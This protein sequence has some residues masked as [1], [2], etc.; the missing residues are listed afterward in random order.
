MKKWRFPAWLLA[1]ALA[2]GG[3]GSLNDMGPPGGILDDGP[4]SAPQRSAS[5]PAAR[6]SRSAGES[7]AAPSVRSVAPPAAPS[8][9]SAAASSQAPSSSEP[10]SI[11]LWELVDAEQVVPETYKAGDDKDSR[12]YTFEYTEGKITCTLERLVYVAAGKPYE[13]EEIV[14]SG[15]W[16][17]P[18]EEAYLP[19]EAVKITLSAAV[20][21]FKRQNPVES[22]RNGT[23]QAGVTVWAYIDAADAPFGD[24][25]GNILTSADGR[26]DCRATINSGK[27][28]VASATL[29]VRSKF[30]PGKPGERKAVIG[31]AYNQGRVGGIKYIFQIP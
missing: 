5:V 28:D 11:G 10:Q 2:L 24:A 9:Q 26:S 3:C 19:E 13:E 21:N 1:A 8:S 17:M 7:S 15:G 20:V 31:A 25:R 22:G 27:I 18:P 16:T 29:G 6:P 30:G 14:T 12:E 4:S 23:N